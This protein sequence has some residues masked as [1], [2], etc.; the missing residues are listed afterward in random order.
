MQSYRRQG[1][2]RGHPRQQG[3]HQDVLKRVTEA[4]VIDRGE[5]DAI[6]RRS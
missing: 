1:R 6:D 3:L 2:A 4:G 5:L